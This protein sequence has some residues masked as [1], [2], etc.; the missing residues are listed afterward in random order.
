LHSFHEYA[1]RY[2]L[3]MRSMAQLPDFGR[4]L[5]LNFPHSDLDDSD[6]QC[7]KVLL[8]FFDLPIPEHVALQLWAT[9]SGESML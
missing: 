9:Y 8:R 4:L 7:V 1:D 6:F 3:H 5:S 2:G